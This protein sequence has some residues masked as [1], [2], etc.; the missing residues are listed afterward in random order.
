MISVVSTWG[1]ISRFTLPSVRRSFIWLVLAVAL[2]W[3]IGCALL[4]NP[5][6]PSQGERL[7]PS[8]SYGPCHG[9]VPTP[10]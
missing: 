6:G 7:F 10:C 9:G 8:N 2:L 1:G 3:S 4:S 5:L